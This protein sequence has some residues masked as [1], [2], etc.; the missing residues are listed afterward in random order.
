MQKLFK[1]LSR[2][3]KKNFDE[4]AGVAAAALAGGL[5]TYGLYKRNQYKKDAEKRDEKTNFGIIQK[6]TDAK[7]KLL[8][9]AGMGGS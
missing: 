4:G 1:A 7:N 3:K 9:D 2:S 5:L 8:K 6:N